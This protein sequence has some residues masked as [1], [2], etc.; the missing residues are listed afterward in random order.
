MIK[1]IRNTRPFFGLFGFVVILLIFYLG[2]VLQ[3]YQRNKISRNGRFTKA[4]IYMIV[5]EAIVDFICLCVI[6]SMG[7]SMKK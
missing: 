1:R 6:Q 3:Q 5:R 4:Y 2:A 7:I